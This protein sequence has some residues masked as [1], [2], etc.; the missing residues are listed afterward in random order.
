MLSSST[1]P[2]FVHPQPAQQAGYGGQCLPAFVNINL[3]YPHPM[4]SGS[5]STSRP[6]V[7]LALP[8]RLVA[9]TDVLLGM[10]NMDMLLLLLSCKAT[11]FC[12]DSVQHIMT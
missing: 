7:S 10:V 2:P 12:K 11:S 9:V 6:I 8:P 3:L 5:S 4:L 1:S